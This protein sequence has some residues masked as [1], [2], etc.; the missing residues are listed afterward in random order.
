MS[1]ATARVTFGSLLGA[2]N[3]ATSVLSSSFNTITKSINM[4]NKYVTDAAEKQS[5]RSIVDMHDFET[6]LQ[7]EKAMEE[8]LRKKQI[9]EFTNESEINK[10]L[11]E[12]A[13]NRIGELLANRNKIS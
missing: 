9:V 3:D 1:T 2:V 5:I 10:E 7:E 6:K 8:T 11:F 12:N 4:A 13:Y